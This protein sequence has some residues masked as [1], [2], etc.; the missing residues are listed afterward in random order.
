MPGSSQN[1]NAKM[2]A[3]RLPSGPRLGGGTGREASAFG[4]PPP[5]GH[6]H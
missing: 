4:L 6:C 1:E 2:A 5:A 3:T